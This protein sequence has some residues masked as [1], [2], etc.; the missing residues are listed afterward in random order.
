MFLRHINLSSV[1][2]IEIIL[3]NS[4]FASNKISRLSITKINRIRIF[5]NMITLYF[6]NQIEPINEKFFWRNVALMRQEARGVTWSE[7]QKIGEL[8]L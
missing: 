8:L 6:E 4:V 7:I 1:K 3:T 5:K 2:D